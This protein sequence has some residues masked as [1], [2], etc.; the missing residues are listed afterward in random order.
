[1]T[2]VLSRA[3]AALLLAWRARPVLL[4]GY[5]AARLLSG[6]LPALAAW[7]TKVGIDRVVAGDAAPAVL[8]VAAALA[9]AGLLAALGPPVLRHVQAEL[10][11]AVAVIAKDRLYAAVGRFTLLQTLEDPA[12][13]DRL[14]M[15]EQAGNG[16]PSQVVDSVLGVAQA[17]VT[18]AGMAGAVA[19][20]S[21]WLAAGLV[22]AALPALVAELRLSRRR[23]ALTF[24]L[25]PA[26]R[27]ELFYTDL[28]TD[29]SAAKEVRLFGAGDLLR[30]RMLTELRAVNAGY[31]R[32][33][34]AELGSQVTLAALSALSAGAAVAWTLVA[35]AAG[36]LSAGD[37]GAVI[38]AVAGVQA[39]LSGGVQYLALAHHAGLLFDHYRALLATPPDPAAPTGAPAAGETG[40]VLDD[41]WFR[42]GDEHPWVLRGVS[43]TIPPGCAV[44]VVGENGSGKSTLV[45]LLCRLYDPTR[46]AIRWDGV[47]LRDLP[48]DA[49]RRRVAA[50]FQDFMCYELTAAENIA[51]GDTDGRTTLDTDPSRLAEP[52]ARAGIH[53]TLLAL[54]GGYDTLLSRT[55]VDYDRPEGVLL[56][57][58]QWQR[59]ALARA[60]LRG[61][62][63]LLILDE[64][65]SGLDA[66]AEHRIHRTIAAHRDGRTS[67]LVSHRLNTVR[68]ADRI[69]VL[70]DGRIAETGTHASLMAAGGRY[71]ALFRLQASGYDLDPASP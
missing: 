36:R 41:V 15:A 27:R 34:R 5:V 8:P 65:S 71:A 14:R 32:M 17:V 21:P 66:A 56:S 10:G 68:D 35:A 63:E 26:E 28:L 23:A 39:A 47:D 7:L 38:L 44:A 58:G 55:F 20:V 40:I 54:P 59:L 22:A 52:A 11:R 51:L 30:H 67:V 50:V 69:V 16:G 60:L 43:V 37:V 61:R 31:R 18:I 29:L 42:Y 24:S 9:A 3:G 19:V 46:G 6:A 64:P 53:D 12:F 62:R 2:A 13:R 57:G 25:S 33:D 4:C 70:A 48:V 49:L 45:K 1:M